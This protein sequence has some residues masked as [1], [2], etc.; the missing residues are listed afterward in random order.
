MLYYKSKKT[1]A[2]DLIKKLALQPH[3]E[4]G[5]FVEIHRSEYL[6]K[7]KNPHYNG[8][9]R[10][11]GSLIYYLLQTTNYSAW[12]RLKSDET[13]HFHTGCPMLLHVIDPKYNF[14]TVILGDLTT[15][16]EATFHASVK[17][18]HWFAAEL[19]DKKSFSLVSCAVYPGFD[20][21]DFELEDKN[22]IATL[23]ERCL[24]HQ[25]T[26]NQLIHTSLK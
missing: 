7:P 9:E 19:A 5:F 11:A 26:I 25:E 12:H 20:F 23:N 3:P 18:G 24:N 15:I 17:A 10:Q 22:T 16:A 6:V 21:K 2:N 1:E 13:W 8:E 14:K 4:G